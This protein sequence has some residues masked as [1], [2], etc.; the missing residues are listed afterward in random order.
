M[1]KHQYHIGQCIAAFFILLVIS[2]CNN[3][4]EIPFPE[5]ELGYSQPEAV[6]LSFHTTKKLNWRTLKSGSVSSVIKHLDIDA[7]PSMP[8]DSTGFK[9]FGKPPEESRFDFNSLRDTVINLAALPSKPIQ[10]KTSVLPPPI[11]IKSLSPALQKGKPLTI[12]DFGPAQGL[13]VKFTTALLKDKAGMMWIAGDGGLYRYDGEH[14]QRIIRDLTGPNIVG[15]LED[16]QG[17]IWFFNN[18]GIGKIDLPKGTVSYSNTI[19][20]DYNSVA[21]IIKDQNGMIW[22]H[23]AKD[24]AIS[25]INTETATYKNID[26]KTGMTDSHSFDLVEDDNKNIWISTYTGGINI[27]NYASGKIKYLGKANGISSDSLSSIIKDPAGNI[28]VS[29]VRGGLDLVNIKSG[30]IRHYTKAQGLREA[31]TVSLAFDEKGRLWRGRR[32]G[33]ELIDY[34]NQMIKTITNTDGLF[35]GNVTALKQDAYHRMWTATTEGLNIIDQDGDQ[36][37]LLGI[38]QVISVMEEITGNIWVATTKGIQIINPKNKTIRLLN[39]TNGLANDFIQGFTT[40]D[41]NIWITSNGGLDIYSPIKKTLEHIGKKEGLANDTLYVAF[42]DKAGNTWFTGPTNGIDLIDSSK[43]IISYA[44]VAGGMSDNSLVDARQDKY[45]KIWLATQ[46]KGVDIYD[47]LTGEIKNINNQPGLKDTCNKMTIEDSFG[48]MWIG[49]DKGIYVVDSKLATITAITTRQGLSSNRILSLVIYGGSVLA[50]TD[51]NVNIITAPL[52]A[53]AAADKGETK[54][55]WSIAILRKS[56]GLSR[57]SV[58]SWSTDGIT[59]NGH[60]LWG[61]YGLSIINDYKAE[62]DSVATYITGINIMTQP[63]YFV[64]PPIL[65][66]KDTLWSAD[67]FY[68]K[69][70]QPVNTGYTTKGVSWDSLSGPFNLPENLRIPYNANYLQFQFVQNHLS[71]RDTTWYSYV[72]EGID[73][74]WSPLTSNT[75]TENYLNLSPGKYTFKVKSVGIDGKWSAPVSFSFTISPPWYNTW[76][77]Y[78]LFVLAGIGI[79]RFYILYRS[80]MLQKENRILE[81]KINHRTQ[82]LQKSIEDLKA[83]Q[84]QLI[85]SEK[86]ASLGELTA[87]IAH[88][89]QNPL[90]FINNFS[91]VNTELIEEMQQEIDK[92]N[93]PEVKA[94]AKDI[95]ENEQKINFHGKRADGIVKG[96]LQHS[97]NS[98]GT[99]EPTN[100]NTLAD[101]Y[102]RLAYH[103]LRA[104]DKSFNASMKT[105]FDENIG[106]INVVSQD[107]GRVILNLIT[108]AFYAVTDKKKK[109]IDGYEPTVFVSTKREGNKVIIKVRDNGMGIPQKVQEKIFQPFF[110][111]KPTGEGTGLG[112]SMSY[113]IVTKGHN[114]ELTVKTVE[115]EYTEFSIV[116]P[117]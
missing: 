6:P 70:R 44:D 84:S 85:Q 114:G 96:M 79:L 108:N 2:S 38:T 24:K 55:G 46:S 69:G 101:E 77:A 54:T 32:P 1:I 3:T 64:K 18:E 106:K 19:S 49:T 29:A 53:Y 26:K 92:G 94:I 113:D 80:R 41:H 115:G 60:F 116:L 23:N 57:Q 61:D 62:T 76:W 51:K 40:Y 39:K 100:I 102:L 56:E 66:E 37:N 87:G 83:T 10:F 98:T 89:I 74:K 68:V 109:N 7:L 91:E 17:K 75:F 34:E 73:K 25:I 28:W 13:P 50:A 86:M 36:A 20:A 31:F 110:T 33:L 21:R 59:K 42:K 8:Y 99:K 72:L 15:L 9:P 11:T 45:G 112:L 81:E 95:K 22:L 5:K 4:A 47:P 48:R 63:Q 117:V 16:N 58:N 52:P 71:R 14:I 12:F 111:T 107:I 78:T 103:G 43:K 97:R 88:E 90:N 104:K 65:N 93:L 30:S 82:Q 67:T 35:D 27:V 105:D